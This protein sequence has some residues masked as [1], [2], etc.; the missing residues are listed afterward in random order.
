MA[1]FEVCSEYAVSVCTALSQFAW[2]KLLLEFLD[3]RMVCFC[4]YLAQTRPE[5]EHGVGVVTGVA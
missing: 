3:F 2:P 1:L 5:Y 4:P